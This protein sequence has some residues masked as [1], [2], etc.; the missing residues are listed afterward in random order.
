ME[1]AL[2]PSGSTPPDSGSRDAVRNNVLGRREGAITSGDRYQ[3]ASA[4]VDQVPV[5]TLHLVSVRFALVAVWSFF[6][7]MSNVPSVVA[8]TQLHRLRAR[9]LMASAVL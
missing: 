1:E 6:L 8:F 7:D 3:K 9:K 4:M 5:P 2:L